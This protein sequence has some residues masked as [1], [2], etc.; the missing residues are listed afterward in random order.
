M[1]V[2]VPVAFSPSVNVAV[3]LIGSPM[4]ALIAALTMVGLSRNTLTKL[5]PPPRGISEG[6][7]EKVALPF[8]RRPQSQRSPNVC[9]W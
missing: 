2:I 7:N 4:V 1:K 6:L 5:P 8:H 3:S 9:A